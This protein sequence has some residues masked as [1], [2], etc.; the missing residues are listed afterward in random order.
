M[1]RDASL[2]EFLPAED[3]SEASAGNAPT[4]DGPDGDS[5]GRSDGTGDG[6][7]AVEAATP[8]YT[9]DWAP[10]GAE[11]GDCGTAVEER[12]RDDG[13][14]VCEACKEW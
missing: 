8:A 2:D 11:C 4:S 6:D 14:L 7:P 3:A 5:G 1:D 13:R 12:W 10:E 9:Y